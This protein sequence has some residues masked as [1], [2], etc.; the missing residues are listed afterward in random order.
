L[1]KNIELVQKRL[2]LQR[3]HEHKKNEQRELEF[4][5]KRIQKLQSR[6]NCEQSDAAKELE[7]K[8]NELKKTEKEWE[9]ICK[10]KKRIEQEVLER[11]K[12]KEKAE[13]LGEFY[14]TEFGKINDKETHLQR[15]INDL[16]EE[17]KETESR[18]DKCEKSCH[19]SIREHLSN[20]TS[21]IEQLAHLDEFANLQSNKSEKLKELLQLYQNKLDK[22]HE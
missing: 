21:P 20:N 11:K 3:E 13:K 6:N 10:E 22:L 1:C 5:R 8:Q 2:V 9:R 19:Y 18:I 16:Q 14:S 15:T 7:K 4:E 12:I 17:L